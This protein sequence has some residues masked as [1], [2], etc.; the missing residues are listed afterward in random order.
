MRKWLKNSAK[1]DPAAVTLS[2]LACVAGL[3][4]IW[5]AL[6]G[7]MSEADSNLSATAAEP[8]RAVFSTTDDVG[9][10]SAIRRAHLTA[11]REGGGLIAI[12]IDDLGGDP[13][14][15]RRAIGLPKPVTLAFLPY[16]ASTPRLAFD[17]NTAGHEIIAH[18]PMQAEKGAYPGL[19]ALELILTP[20]ENVSRLE[21][22]LSRVPFAIGINNHM[23][24]R[25]TADAAA[26][27]PVMRV[28]KAR[29]LF[30]FDSRTTTASQVGRVAA[31]A[32]VPS[33]ERD[34]FLDDIRT[35][36]AV[37]AELTRADRIARELGVAIVIGHPHKVTLDALEEWVK[38]N[39][40]RL[41]PLSQAL[42]L[43]SE[44]NQARR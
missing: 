34:V 44:R 6:A 33:A 21:G 15:T 24:S 17:G 4:A 5:A 25:F 20:Q 41:I 35:P 19:E 27:V 31:D 10:G 3:F 23:G 38:T 9:R 2:V 36:E 16:P 26:L 39:R 42:R 13:A 37:R 28:L 1:W 43:K 30:F 12:V 18:V 29:R 32:G 14:A 8:Q 22:A 11:A 40:T 7:V